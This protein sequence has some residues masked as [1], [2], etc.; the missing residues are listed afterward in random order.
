MAISIWV[1]C[2]YS[3][4]VQKRPCSKSA[5]TKC[6][7][8]FLTPCRRT[9]KTSC[10][11]K[12]LFIVWLDVCYCQ[13]LSKNNQFCDHLLCCKSII[14]VLFTFSVLIR[15]IIVCFFQEPYACSTP[16]LHVLCVMNIYYTLI[17]IT[18]LFTCTALF[19]CIVLNECTICIYM[20]CVLFTC[21]VC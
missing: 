19:A 6:I 12:H 8:K 3:W 13:V 21:S 4:A 18:M 10:S 1:D 14:C 5:S 9:P 16:Q 2:L 7:Q 17:K 20:Y 11:S 15:C